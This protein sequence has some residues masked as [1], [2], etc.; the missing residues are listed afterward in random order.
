MEVFSQLIVNSLIASAI[1]VLVVEHNIKS[2]L[3][4]VDRAYL[5]DKGRVLT[6]GRPSELFQTDILEKVFL[7]KLE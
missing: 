4:I 2:L 7:G 5:L 6:S 1:Y 3:E